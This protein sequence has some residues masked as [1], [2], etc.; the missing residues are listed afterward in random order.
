MV[1]KHFNFGV[2]IGAGGGDLIFFNGQRPF[3]QK[4]KCL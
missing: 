1:P 4:L 2:V 3:E